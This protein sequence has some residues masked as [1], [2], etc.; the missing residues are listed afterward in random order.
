MKVYIVRHRRNG[1]PWQED[2]FSVPSKAMAVALFLECDGHEVQYEMID[3]P[4]R[5]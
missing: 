3:D 5:N 2:A 4:E 1:E